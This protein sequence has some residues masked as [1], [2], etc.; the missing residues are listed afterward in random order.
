L[1][2][3]ILS[4]SLIAK[5]SGLESVEQKISSYVISAVR[6]VRICSL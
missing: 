5:H 3:S 6:F 2:S 1:I 4:R